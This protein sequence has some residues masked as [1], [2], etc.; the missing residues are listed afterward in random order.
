MD[1]GE[2]SGG[3]FRRLKRLYNREA[4]NWL[5]AAQMIKFLS[6]EG[7]DEEIKDLVSG[8]DLSVVQGKSG[9]ELLNEWAR[10]EMKNGE[11]LSAELRLK[12]SL[13]LDQQNPKTYRILGELYLLKKAD[14]PKALAY[15][16][17]YIHLAANDPDAE[18]I[19]ILVSDLLSSFISKAVQ[20]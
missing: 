1:C 14:L 15:L 12:R 10:Y 7:R 20:P 13:D 3:I 19:K 9:A 11:D 5:V 2:Y 17:N 6:H 16:K 18:S 8:I 4:D